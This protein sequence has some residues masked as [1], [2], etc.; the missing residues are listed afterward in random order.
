MELKEIKERK[1]DMENEIA[2]ILAKFMNET[3]T[4]VVDLDIHRDEL[5]YEGK[6]GIFEV[7]VTVRCDVR[8]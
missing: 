8:V 7:S 5:K 2:G 3:Q 6:S 4:E 1:S